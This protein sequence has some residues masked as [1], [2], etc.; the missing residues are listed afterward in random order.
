M[1]RRKA[2]RDDNNDR[3]WLDCRPTLRTLLLPNSREL[4][5]I[6][7]NGDRHGKKG[8]WVERESAASELR[9]C[10]RQSSREF[11]WLGVR[12]PPFQYSC[13]GQGAA[14]E[15]VTSVRGGGSCGDNMAATQHHAPGMFVPRVFATRVISSLSW[16][17][18]IPRHFLV[19]LISD[20]CTLYLS[21][22]QIRRDSQSNCQLVFL[23]FFNRAHAS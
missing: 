17:L 20:E 10:L 11:H 15:E 9:H 6:H 18:F 14:A 19:G 8:G 4:P 12:G 13:S 16:T 22:P 21:V 23:P 7:Q 1:K 3:Q 2:D 5:R